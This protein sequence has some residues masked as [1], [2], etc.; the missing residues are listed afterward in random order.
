[1]SDPDSELML[2]VRAGDGTAFEV[3]VGRFLRPLVRYFHRM[4]ADASLAE[5]CAQDVF[6]K[7][8]RMR[9]AYEARAKFSTFLFRVARNHWIDVYRHRAAAPPAV[10]SDATSDP[11]QG[12]LS[13]RLPSREGGPD[14]GAETD[15]LLE[16]LRV[17]VTRLPPE[18]REVLALTRS[19]NLRYEEVASILEI[20]VGTVKSRMHAAVLAL[21]RLLERRAGRRGE[22]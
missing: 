16:A 13:D 7:L 19:G 21:R 8:Y 3:L 12:T 22:P 17:A 20:P 1:V 10:S 9:V 18:H 6:L 4:G 14:A 5:D 15:E 2:R 11:E